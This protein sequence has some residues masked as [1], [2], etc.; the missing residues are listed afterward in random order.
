M[1]TYESNDKK[2]EGRQQFL[3]S[4]KKNGLEFEEQDCSVS[5]LSL[6]NG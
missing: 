2:K 3:E 6:G 4:G 1:L 5:I